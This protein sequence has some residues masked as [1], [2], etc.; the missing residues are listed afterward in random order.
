[1]ADIDV[2]SMFWEGTMCRTLVHELGSE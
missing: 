1:V 2:I